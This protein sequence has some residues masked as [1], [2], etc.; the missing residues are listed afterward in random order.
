MSLKNFCQIKIFKDKCLFDTYPHKIQITTKM[1]E[2]NDQ[3]N[4]D[5][6]YTIDI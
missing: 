6:D 3:V 5:D 2:M 1:A 4:G